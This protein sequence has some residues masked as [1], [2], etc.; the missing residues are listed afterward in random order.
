[1]QTVSFVYVCISIG[2]LNFVYPFQYM[3]LK[4]SVSV[5]VLPPLFARILQF[6]FVRMF[7]LKNK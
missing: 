1:M 4:R 6:S 2:I 5:T 7:F 3:Y